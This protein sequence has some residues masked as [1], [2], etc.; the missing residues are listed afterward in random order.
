MT[1]LRERADAAGIA[2]DEAQYQRSKPLLE[3]QIKALIARDLW[4]M[5]E[6]YA[7]MNSSNESVQ[8]AIKVLTSGIYEQLLGQTS[9]YW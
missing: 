6:Y 3:L 8:Q 9:T 1:D 2:F 5:N 7:I 4:D